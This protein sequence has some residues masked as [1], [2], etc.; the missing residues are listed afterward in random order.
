MIFAPSP[1]PSLLSCVWSASGVL[2][3]VRVCV[4][5]FWSWFPF[6]CF[7][8]RSP[9]LWILS[10][11]FGSREMVWNV[12]GDRR[13]I[14]IYHR[15]TL[16]W[17]WQTDHGQ[18]ESLVLHVIDLDLMKL[19]TFLISVEDGRGNDKFLWRL[20][21]LVFR[22][23]ASDTSNFHLAHRPFSICSFHSNKFLLPN[24]GIFKTVNSDFCP[25]EQSMNSNM[26]LLSNSRFIPS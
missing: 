9:L 18:A 19:S 6:S 5:C 10:A 1:L 4:H 3:L 25:C 14:I 22:W 8:R 20:K 12:E 7:C 11:I 26:S 15:W 2:S 23:L 13:R 21:I 17:G 24:S 16:W